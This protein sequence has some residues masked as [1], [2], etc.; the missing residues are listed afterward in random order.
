MKEQKKESNER[1]GKMT[2][3]H[4]QLGKTAWTSFWSTLDILFPELKGMV[5]E[6]WKKY[7]TET[8]DFSVDGFLKH[9][10]DE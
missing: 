10:D 7:V 5:E 9:I 3:N 6:M 4:R 8:G 2:F 1:E